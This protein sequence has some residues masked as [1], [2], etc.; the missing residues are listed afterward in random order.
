MQEVQKKS[1]SWEA[2]YLSK[3]I[4]HSE[5]DLCFFENEKLVGICAGHETQSNNNRSFSIE[6]LAVSPDH[7]N[8]G[9]AK[10][11]LKYAFKYFNFKL[12]L[13]LWTRS[14]EAYSYYKDHLNLKITNEVSMNN[15]TQQNKQ[16]LF[17]D[18]NKKP[19]T[20]CFTITPDQPFL[21]SIT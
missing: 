12:E 17:T 7:T 10:K 3:P 16:Y 6:I 14:E 13:I 15:L 18:L 11:L 20:W 1:H 2:L 21:K 4:F 5:M 9:I 19:N 8:R